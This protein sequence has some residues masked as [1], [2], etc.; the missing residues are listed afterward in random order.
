MQI[1]SAGINDFEIIHELA[2]TTWWATYKDI[3]SA[4]QLDYMF[5][6]MY[7]HTSYMEQINEQGHRYLLVSYNDSYIGFA[8]YELHYTAITTKIHKLYVLPQQQGRGAGKLLL[9]GVKAEAL[10]NNDTDITLNVNRFNPSVHFYLKSGFINAGQEDIAI[11]NGYLMEDY[12]M[13]L[14]LKTL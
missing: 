10:S 5:D 3:L 13:Q 7:S 8:S 9:E 4:E 1:R 2:T 12:I 11:G 14:P 6:M